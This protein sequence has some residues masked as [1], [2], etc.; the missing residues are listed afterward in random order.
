[1]L[2]MKKKNKKRHEGNGL[3]VTGCESRIPYSV[4][5]RPGFT[6]IEMLIV[7]AILSVVALAVFATLNNGIKI[8]QKVNRQLPEEDLNI[9]FDKFAHDVKNTFKFTGIIFSGTIEKVEFPTLVNS[10]R[11]QKRTVGKLIYAYEPETRILNRYQVDFAGVYSGESKAS[12]QQTLKNVR[13]LKFQYYL[14]NEQNKVYL[15]QDEYGYKEG[16]PLA[17]RVELEFDDGAEIKKFTKTVS[18]PTSG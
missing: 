11:L 16:L 15:W 8:W 14:Y 13:A 1:M 18:I 3:R 4:S 5:R 10:L 9:F 7:T 12:P 6:L 17:V 2:C